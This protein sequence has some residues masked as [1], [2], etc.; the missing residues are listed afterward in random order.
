MK[1][2]ININNVVSNSKYSGKYIALESFVSDK[3]IAT[4]KDVANVLHRAKQKSLDP[5]IMFIPEE[6]L[7]CIYKAV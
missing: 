5:V 3:V 6:K 2:E 7:T 4:G 1:K